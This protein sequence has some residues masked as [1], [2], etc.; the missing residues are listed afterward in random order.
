MRQASQGPKLLVASLVPV[1]VVRHSP[2]SGIRC[3]ARLEIDLRSMSPSRRTWQVK[4]VQTKNELRKHLHT[5]QQLHW[6][7]LH[8]ICNSLGRRCR[9]ASYVSLHHGLMT[10]TFVFHIARKLSRAAARSSASGSLPGP[11]QA[12]A[13]FTPVYISTWLLTVQLSPSSE[14]NFNSFMAASTACIRPRLPVS[15]GSENQGMIK[16]LN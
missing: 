1:V 9:S 6:P 5:R 12:S 11:R 2:Q 3:A 15:T 8:G 4:A 16:R 7:V 13:G 14:R 10:G